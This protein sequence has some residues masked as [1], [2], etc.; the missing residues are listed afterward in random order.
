MCRGC[1]LSE[2]GVHGAPKGQEYS[3]EIKDHEGVLRY[4]VK[5]RT[6]LPSRLASC[7]FFDPSGKKLCVMTRRVGAFGKEAFDIYTTAPNSTGQ[8]ATTSQEEGAEGED[9]FLFGVIEK[10]LMALQ[11]EY[12]L[13]SGQGNAVPM[14]AAPVLKA[15]QENNAQAKVG[16]RPNI[17]VRDPAANG[18]PVVGKA[19]EKGAL[20][21]PGYA[22]VE[23]RRQYVLECGKGMDLLSVVAI[24]Q[25]LEDL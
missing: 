25:A 16:W 24:A 10:R 14:D 4:V 8:E 13:V 7:A 15:V 1:F 20:M 21:S 12:K 18:E 2:R 22:S 9:I 3:F 6:V 11:C 23:A 19:G 17:K 5:R